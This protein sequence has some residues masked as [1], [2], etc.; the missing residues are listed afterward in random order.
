MPWTFDEIEREWFGDGHLAWDGEDVVRAFV[1]AERIR[2]RDWVLGTEV[3]PGLM[4]ALP[5][6]GRRGGYQEFLRVCW[7]GKRAASI[8]GARGADDFIQRLIVGDSSTSQEASAIHLLRARNYD[9][10][11]EIAPTIAVGTHNRQPDFRIR[12]PAEDWIYVEVT[13]LN[14]ST[15]SAQ[16]MALLQRIAERVMTISAPFLLEVLLNR[17]PVGASEEEQLITIAE[18]AS[19]E[20]QGRQRDVGD[21]GSM[22]VKAGDP[23]VVVPSLLETDN[24]PR[25]AVARALIGPGQLNRQMIARVPFQDQRAEEILRIEARQLPRSE[26]GIVMV[27][28][29]RQPSAFESW[30]L[31]VPE[32]FAGGQHTR[33]AAV[34]LFMHATMATNNG[35][36]WLPFLRVIQNPRATKP[37]PRWIVET[38][39]AIRADTRRITGRPD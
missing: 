32:R 25:M 14:E 36:M 11:L 30:S 28:V 39:E 20:A 8:V 38:L 7:F 2:G 33:I 21:L 17:D 12:K 15:A 27:N 26:C 3:D 31:R 22:L 10:E 18:T 23:Q 5:G 16:T 34:V 19:R 1:L 24:R 4:Q 6:I 37:L 13:A 29:N 35:L 9:T